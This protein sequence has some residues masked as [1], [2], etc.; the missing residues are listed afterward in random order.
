[1]SWVHVH[2]LLNHVPV[3]G[4]LGAMLVLGIGIVKRSQDVMRVGLG[5]VVLV[6]VMSVIVYLTGEPAEELVEHLPGVSESALESHEDAAYYATV[7]MTLIGVAVAAG[8]LVYRGAPSVPRWFA[9]W[10]LL[11]AIAAAAVMTW[12]AGLGG[13]IRHSEI[14]RD[15]A[16]PAA[17]RAHDVSSATLGK[18]WLTRPS[19]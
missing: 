17:E 9:V 18:P 10:T 7:V 5:L 14:R 19:T 13:Q 8:L 11:L 1:M 12:T 3:I 16:A 4:V 2:L 6:A 15:D